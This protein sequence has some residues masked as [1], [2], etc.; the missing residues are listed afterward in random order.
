MATMQ[1][2][3]IYKTD[4]NEVLA[5]L[6]NGSNDQLL[7]AIFKER[8]YNNPTLMASVDFKPLFERTY[9]AK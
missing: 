6:K 1:K 5:L 7:W 2:R 4:K 8:K 3:I 9:G